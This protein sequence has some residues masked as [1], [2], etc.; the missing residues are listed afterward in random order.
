MRALQLTITIIAGILL[1]F[2]AS[3][4]VTTIKLINDSVASEGTLIGYHETKYVKNDKYKTATYSYY[5]VVKFKTVT[6][7]SITFTGNIGESIRGS[8]PQE[9]ST[10][11]VVPVIYPQSNPQN[12]RINSFL[13]LFGKPV[14]LLLFSAFL[15][16]MTFFLSLFSKPFKAL[17]KPKIN[18]VKLDKVRKK[19]IMV[20]KQV[21]FKKEKF[22]KQNRTSII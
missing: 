4:F 20:M 17:R 13:T 11:K 19:L 15:F 1:F 2:S 8:L 21:K 5:P 14:V 22:E 12:A 6:G 3:N 9:D 18:K 16:G 7:Q 10:D